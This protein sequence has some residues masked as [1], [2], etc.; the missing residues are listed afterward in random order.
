MLNQ[1]Q[2]FELALKQLSKN[3]KD[4]YQMSEGDIYS[5]LVN[6]K[7]FNLLG[8]TKF[9]KDIRTMA[10]IN[11]IIPDYYCVDDNEKTI[12]VLEAKKPEDENETPL[13]IY[14]DKQLKKYTSPLKS[15]FGILTNGIKFILFKRIDNVLIELK[16]IADLEYINHQDSLYIYDCLKKSYLNLENI[17]ELHQ[18]LYLPDIDLKELTLEGRNDFYQIF[19]LSETSKFGELVS[20]FNSLLDYS[21]ENHFKFTTGAFNFWRKSYANKLEEVPKPWKNFTNEENLY[22]F[23]F[24]LE[25]A[26]VLVSRLILARVAEDESFPDINIR[27]MIQSLLD[28]HKYRGQISFISYPKIISSCLLSLQ[29]RLVE[30]VFEEDL[31]NWWHDAFKDE[32]IENMTP[33]ELIQYNNNTLQDFGKK[34]ISIVIA[35]YAFKFRDIED[36]IG[37]LYQEYFDKETRKA[38]GEFY[39]PQSI[40]DYIIDSVGYKGFINERL[41]DPAC[42]SGTFIVQALKKFFN[43]ADHVLDITSGRDWCYFL[44]ELCNKTKIVGFDINPFAVLMA[45]IRFMIELIP[46]YK[47]AIE[48]N[49]NYTIKSL[50]IFMTDSLWSEK[51]RATGRQDQ[52]TGFMTQ[53]GG[54]I[55]FRIDLPLEN[56]EEDKNRFVQ[57]K[58][59]IPTQ[60]KLGL[61][62]SDQLFGILQNLF[63]YIKQ[64]NKR[65]EY[66]IYNSF[67]DDFLHVFNYRE[68]DFNLDRVIIE[69][70]KPANLLLNEIKKLK[71]KYDDG[72]LIKWIEDRVL[73]GILKNYVLFDYVVGNP[74]WISKQVKNTF[75]STEYQNQLVQLYTSANTDFDL[76][77]V[78]IEKGLNS[79][80]KFGKLGFITSNTFFKNSYGQTIRA[81]L[82]Q[83]KIEKIIDFLDYD[84]FEDATNYSSI[85]IVQKTQE[86]LYRKTIETDF[87][88]VKCYRI[89]YWANGKINTLIQAIRENQNSDD[90]EIF[91][92]PYSEFTEK[93]HADKKNLRLYEVIIP[94]SEFN[95]QYKVPQIKKIP[96]SD[97]WIIA[98]LSELN[99]MKIIENNSQKRLGSCD[100]I[101][102]NRKKQFAKNNIISDKIFVGIQLNGK[103]AYVVN[104]TEDLPEDKIMKKDKIYAISE[105]YKENFTLETKLLRLL[106]DGKNIEKWITNW[107]GELVLFPYEIVDNSYKLISPLILKTK[108]PNTY[109]YF[110]KIEVL[111]YLEKSSADRKKLIKLLME[112]LEVKNLDELNKSLGEVDKINKL[113]QDLWWYRYIYRKNLESI[114]KSKILVAT[115]SIESR[116]TGDLSGILAPHN[117]RVYSIILPHKSIPFI[118]SLLNSE[119]IAFYLRH[120]ALI[121]KGKTYELIKQVLVTIPI[122]KDSQKTHLMKNIEGEYRKLINLKKLMKKIENFPNSYFEDIEEKEVDKI[123]FTPK[124]DNLRFESDIQ[125]GGKG[126]FEIRVNK[127][128]I[129]SHLITDIFKA[130]YLNKSIKFKSLVKGKAINIILPRENYNCKNLLDQLEKDNKM[131]NNKSL[132]FYE[133]NINE[134]VYE[135]YD[136]KEYKEIIKTFL[137]KYSYEYL[138]SKK[139]NFIII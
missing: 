115:T 16:N 32:P 88:S 131:V 129:K 89:C 63:S 135:Y 73:A 21:L 78:F 39:T 118:I 51:G 128:I 69:L 2:E 47:K 139:N 18:E 114:N 90:L 19:K 67:K 20:S 109:E 97:I 116:F 125:K 5:N 24:S 53:E 22:K 120:I 76:H 25:T 65:S 49:R 68:I 101:R 85:I 42:G 138:S 102:E 133:D 54:N 40:A 80:K 9:G 45:Q 57:L 14:K 44:D 117:V 11:K 75:L 84:L 29:D 38:L 4:N 108:F 113:P 130:E 98:P 119:V 56:I 91:D 86:D 62:N 61:Q 110:S 52:I 81:I 17:D 15:K 3:V 92:I 124:Y 1:A 82:T 41:L 105:I 10:T 66:I 27:S 134:Y 87:P 64:K 100:Q 71:E 6:I 107:K 137:F 106:I 94:L 83:N 127:E 99:I 121:K 48:S 31:F 35:L 13:Y 60:G 70:E 104:S 132:K 111:K 126:L 28:Q 77:V 33:K 59:E 37:D 58:F 30:S 74:P 26:H 112:K 7:F 43:N 12:F 50:P 123:T 8:Y 79:L 122:K 96:F 36:I 46:Y 93:I 72:R 95:K 23:M 34:V 103:K 55:I 136:M